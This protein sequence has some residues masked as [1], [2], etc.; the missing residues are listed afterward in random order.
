[1][2]W[3]YEKIEGNTKWVKAKRNFP[4]NACLNS[5][6]FFSP[7]FYLEEMSIADKFANST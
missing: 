1:M 4:A 5:N 6:S 3:F 2:G 7:G